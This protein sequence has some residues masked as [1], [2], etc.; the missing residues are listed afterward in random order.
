MEDFYNT[1]KDADFLI[2]N[3]TIDDPVRNLE[4][5]CARSSLLREFRAVKNGNVWQVQKNLYQS[6]DIAAAMITDIHR[7]LTGEDTENM[8]FLSPVR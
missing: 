1:A 5:L 3:A 6:P 2:Y 7:M 8:V 4:D